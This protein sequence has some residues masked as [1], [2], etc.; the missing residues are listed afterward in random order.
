[1]NKLLL[2]LGV[3]LLI[4]GCSNETPVE[5][6]AQQPIVPDTNLPSL[7]A[8]DS[9]ILIENSQFSPHT[10]T[11]SK[12]ARVEWFNKMDERVTVVVEGEFAEE[13]VEFGSFSHVFSESGSYSYFSLS[14]PGMSGTVTVN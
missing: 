14:H 12:G 9:Q 1:M 3:L 11:V 5:E 13:I 4:V 2:V 7:E 10:L 8:Q 6:T